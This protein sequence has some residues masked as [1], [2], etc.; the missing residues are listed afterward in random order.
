[1]VNGLAFSSPL[2]S[3]NALQH[4][5]NSSI[6]KHTDTL[7]AQTAMQ[8]ANCSS[9]AVWGSVSCSRILQRAA[10]GVNQRPSDYSTIVQPG[11]ENSFKVL[12]SSN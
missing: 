7:M 10:R 11:A 1:M 12:I 4:S 5:S 9:E 3:Q 6:H 8:G 2:T